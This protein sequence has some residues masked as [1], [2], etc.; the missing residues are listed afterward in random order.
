MAEVFVEHL[1]HLLIAIADSGCF[2]L[3][4]ERPSDRDNSDNPRPMNPAAWRS[5]P[6]LRRASS[7][8]DRIGRARRCFF[9]LY[10]A[11]PVTVGLL[12]AAD[13]LE[14]QPPRATF[15]RHGPFPGM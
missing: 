15:G 9:D 11:G 13:A 8:V 1:R 5:S 4:D 2:D 3:L 12:F 7:L 10:P 6:P 14:R